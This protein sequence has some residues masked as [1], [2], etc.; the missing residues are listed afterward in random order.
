M[1]RHAAGD[2]DAIEVH[3]VDR[4]QRVVGGAALPPEAG[5]QA[6]VLEQ[7]VARADPERVRAV[8]VLRDVKRR[9]RRGRAVADLERDV[10]GG[11]QQLLHRLPALVDEVD[12]DAELVERLQQRAHPQ[13]ERKVQL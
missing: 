8:P 11:E 6:Q 1:H 2:E 3:E 12:V 5:V 4:D 9:Y 7:V 13:I 10:L